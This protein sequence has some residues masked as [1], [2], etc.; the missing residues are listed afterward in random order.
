[1]FVI[2]VFVYSQ[3]LLGLQFLN[4]NKSGEMA[5]IVKGFQEKYVAKDGQVILHPTI[6]N[7][8]QL[9]EERA[10]NVQWTYHFGDTSFERLE[11]IE[12]TFSEF[13]LKMCL[14]EVIQVFI[15]NN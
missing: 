8:D 1:M 2:S 14:Y 6:M 7:G 5:D 3:C 9:T 15:N 12:L 10:R 13:H 11:G 4:S